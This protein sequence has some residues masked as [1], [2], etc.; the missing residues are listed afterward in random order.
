MEILYDIVITLVSSALLISIGFFSRNILKFFRYRYLKYFIGDSKQITIVLPSFDVEDFSIDGVKENAKIPLNIKLMPMNEGKAIAKI[1]RI[2]QEVFPDIEILLES[3]KSFTASE[4]PFIC[5]GGPSVNSI[6]KSI[7]GEHFS[8]FRILYPEHKA[9]RDSIKYE[10][11]YDSRGNL[12]EDFGF[13]F[14]T[15]HAGTRAIVLCGVW[16]IGTEI[17]CEYFFS[18]EFTK[19]KIAR[20]M[21]ENKNFQSIIH[22]EISNYQI[23]N[24]REISF[25]YETK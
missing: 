17:A 21:K 3:H 9:E 7:L 14:H 1:S 12:K 15:P 11:K 2:F 22:G 6:S 8:S 16:A 10:P 25:F 13:V 24:I 5:I 23:H 19:K 4:K 20:I 18:R